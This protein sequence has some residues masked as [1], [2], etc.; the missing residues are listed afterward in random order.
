MH[1][2]ARGVL[3]M[4][5]A[6][7]LTLAASLGT[8]GTSEGLR[9]WRFKVYLDDKPIGWHSFELNS[10]TGTL[11][12]RAHYQVKVLFV[13]AYRYEHDATEAWDGSCLKR[14]EARTDD[15]GTV[16]SLEGQR[17]ADG[18]VVA[19]QGKRDQLPA[20][21]QSFA[22]W[23][24]SILS[25]TRLLNAQTGEYVAV[26]TTRLGPQQLS[27]RG[28]RVAAQAWRI[29]ARNMQID[30]WYSEDNQWLALQSSTEGGRLLRYE[31]Q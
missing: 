30:L 19:A 22:Y 4:V 26:Q 8:A 27:V 18:F 23:D 16:S 25:A 6:S 1:R 2:R 9:A 17:G 11:R 21:V 20:C 13:T 10:A 28:Q 3:C 14:L 5:A 15:N 24:P 12:S 7:A 29:R 31:L